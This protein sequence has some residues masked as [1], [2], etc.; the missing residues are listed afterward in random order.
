MP[1]CDAGLK[2]FVGQNSSHR[3]AC[4]RGHRK[5]SRQG[6]WA[7]ASSPATGDM[8]LLPPARH[9][10]HILRSSQPAG[11]ITPESR[12]N[13]TLFLVEQGGKRKL[14]LS[15]ALFAVDEPSVAM[16]LPSGFSLLRVITCS[17]NLVISQG[18]HF[19]PAS[20]AEQVHC[21]TYDVG[22][23][24]VHHLDHGVEHQAIS[25]IFVEPKGAP[26]FTAGLSFSTEVSADLILGAASRARQRMA[27]ATEFSMPVIVPD[28]EADRAGAEDQRQA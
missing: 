9:R 2:A 23:A 28:H 15:G 19:L 27:Q 24:L 21:H 17:A 22:C 10:S 6:G 7:Q 13:A 5:D 14:A 4:A 16:P 3:H 8:N 1:S 26:P 12:L 11:W 20:A 18:P 25:V